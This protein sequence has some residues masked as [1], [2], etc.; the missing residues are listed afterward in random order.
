MLCRL[1]DAANYGNWGMSHSSSP[2]ISKGEESDWHLK[3]LEFW[4]ATEIWPLTVVILAEH[5]RVG[6]QGIDFDDI[7]GMV[8]M[9]LGSES[10]VA[11]LCL[12]NAL[13]RAGIGWS[14]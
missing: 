9:D 1:E 2:F 7:S 10:G 6:L 11:L 5:P 4:W 12:L 8:F 3:A 13:D 14:V